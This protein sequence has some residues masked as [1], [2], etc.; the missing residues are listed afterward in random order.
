MRSPYQLHWTAACRILLY[1]KRALDKGL[2][3]RSFSYL[4]I[5]GYFDAYW[6]VILL[7]VI[8]LLIIALFLEAI[9]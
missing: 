2:Y 9:W 1:L 7:V 8:L 3:Y 4:D 6:L 5:V